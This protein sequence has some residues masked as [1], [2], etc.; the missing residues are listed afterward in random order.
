VDEIL[1]S[2]R[3]HAHEL[4]VMSPS[5]IEVVAR[6]RDLCVTGQHVAYCFDF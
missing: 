2:L 5:Q 1:R 4:T 3:A 6:L